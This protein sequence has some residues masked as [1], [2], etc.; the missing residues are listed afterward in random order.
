MVRT[1][2][3]EAAGRAPMAISLGLGIIA[4]LAR[5]PSVG[6]G[7]MA[8]QLALL[9]VRKLEVPVVLTDLDLGMNNW[10][11]DPFPYPEVPLRRGKVLDADGVE[12]R[13]DV[14]LAEQF[15]RHAR[16][17]TELARRDQPAGDRFAGRR[18]AR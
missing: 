18:P 9:F 15:R 16:G 1:D 5:A 8:S 12:R 3:I 17:D 14:E 2:E 13:A 7:L 10:M 6:A 4:L 11:C